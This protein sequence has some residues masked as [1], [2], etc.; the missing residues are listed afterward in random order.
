MRGNI[1]DWG[2][3]DY[4]DIMSGVDYLIAQGIAPRV[5]DRPHAERIGSWLEHAVR[6]GAVR[7]VG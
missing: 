4:R 1:P 3:G 5:D 6:L 7:I 2:G